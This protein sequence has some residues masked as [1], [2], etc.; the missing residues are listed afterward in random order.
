MLHRS[1]EGHSYGVHPVRK[2]YTD[3]CSP[4]DTTII[5]WDGPYA[6][7]R[8][9]E[10]YPEY[11]ANRRSKEESKMMFFDIS[12]AV[13]RFTPCIQIECEGWEADDVIGTLINRWYAKY[14]LV[15]ESNDGDYWQHKD[16]CLLPMVSKKWH[17]FSAEDTI[18]YKALVGDGKDNIPGIRGFGPKAWE[19][20]TSRARKDLRAA[21]KANNFYNFEAV[22]DWPAKVPRT[23]E[24]FEALCLYWK[25]NKYW[26]VPLKEIDDVTFIGKQNLQAAELFMENYLI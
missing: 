10:I 22:G 9:K 14:R 18:L 1:V 5:V 3:L 17:H 13:L 11:K 12:K 7:K 8:R 21:I 16:K 25:L 24:V 15:V 20:L 2:L 6:N 4:P 19:M 26:E 23:R